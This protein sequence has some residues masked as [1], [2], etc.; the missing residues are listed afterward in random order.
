MKRVFLGFCYQGTDFI[1]W[2]MRSAG[3]VG[4]ELEALALPMFFFYFF[5]ADAESLTL[6]V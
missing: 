5:V 4:V 1:E 6:C 2:R 3:D